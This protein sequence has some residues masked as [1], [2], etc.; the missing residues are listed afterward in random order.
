MKPTYSRAKIH[1]PQFIPKVLIA[2][3][4]L[5]AVNSVW[6]LGQTTRVNLTPLGKQSFGD[7]TDSQGISANGRFVV[8]YT[9]ASDLVPGDTNQDCFDDFCTPAADVFVHDQQTNRTVRISVDS[10]GKQGNASSVGGPIS[11]DGRYVAFESSASNLVAND[12]N[13][14]TSDVFVHDLKTRKTERVS[15][16]SAGKQGKGSS[17]SGGIAI[18]GDG[19]FVAFTS[20]DDTLVERDTN[21][22]PD[23]FVHD[24]KTKQ[25]TRVS[26]DSFG[27]EAGGDFNYSSSPDIS[28]DG[29]FVAFFSDSPSLFSG[30]SFGLGSVFI[31][32]RIRHTTTQIGFGNFPSLSANGRY[33]AFSSF[34][35][36]IFD[37]HILVYDT[38]LHKSVHDLPI[39][40][41]SFPRISANGQSVVFV[42]EQADLVPGDTNN[43]EDVFVADLAKNNI[44]RVSINSEG[45]EGD[46]FSFGQYLS[47]DGRFVAFRSDATNLVDNDTNGKTDVFVHDRCPKKGTHEN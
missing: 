13:G 27:N 15:V 5:M 19:R 47:A 45:I 33:L 18:S 17:F 37:T 42:S 20:D 29:R 23:V 38:K 46:N 32:D 26:V 40:G 34:D 30:N 39:G 1:R 43:T 28:A 22:V 3:M 7:F 6:A 31:H 41:T 4:M 24:R 8:F 10:S 11:A 36:Q 14:A 35:P 12:T 25:T 44:S 16:T 2:V 9:D 21:G